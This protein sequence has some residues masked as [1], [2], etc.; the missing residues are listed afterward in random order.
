MRKC[1]KCGKELPSDH[2]GK[3]CDNCEGKTNSIIKKTGTVVAGVLGTILT[4][5]ILSKIFKRK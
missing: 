5:G 3:I 2:K 1:K 4:S